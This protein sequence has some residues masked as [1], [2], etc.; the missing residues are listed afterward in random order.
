MKGSFKPS[1]STAV[2]ALIPLQSYSNTIS[3]KPSALQPVQSYNNTNS[4]N[5]LERLNG[6]LTYNRNSVYR[7]RISE[8][9]GAILPWKD[10]SEKK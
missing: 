3:V 7:W 5:L 4:V 9:M 6:I 2:L 8:S 1:A 10:Y